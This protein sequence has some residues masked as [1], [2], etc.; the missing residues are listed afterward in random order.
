MLSI[1]QSWATQG[2]SNTF[3]CFGRKR[4]RSHTG[5]QINQ[6][7][8]TKSLFGEGKKFIILDEVDFMTKNA[9][10]AL[11]YLIQQYNENVCFCLIC[12]YISR[13]DN[14]LQNEFIRLKFNKLPDEEIVTF[15][16]KICAQEKLKL[17][18][19]D[20]INIQQ[21]YVSDIRSMINY[22]Q[23]NNRNVYSKDKIVT[24][25]IFEKLISYVKKN[26]KLLAHLNKL[27]VKLDTRKNNFIKKFIFYEIKNKDYSRR[28][29]VLTMFKNIIRGNIDNEMYLYPYV[30][31]CFVKIYTNSV[32]FSL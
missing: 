3:K 22:L 2:S 30:E 25:E 10:Q 9:Q 5:N 27:C 15:L 19:K 26:K 24:S 23:S 29:D 11:R 32:D 7:V 28:K 1:A 20:L 31:I 21:Q 13:I 16:K 14:S 12:N 18:P 6:F 8:N 4:N 17:K